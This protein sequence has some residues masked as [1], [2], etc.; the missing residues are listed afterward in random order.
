[1]DISRNIKDIILIVP[2]L[3]VLV[4]VGTLNIFIYLFLLLYSNLIFIIK[5]REKICQKKI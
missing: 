2:W 1:M 5:N 4:I 3:L